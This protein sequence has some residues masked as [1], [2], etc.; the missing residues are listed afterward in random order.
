MAPRS[1]VIVI[2]STFFKR[3]FGVMVARSV[4]LKQNIYRKEIVSETI[5]E[6]LQAR[7]AIE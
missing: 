7:T 5:N 1:T 3:V 4:H 2:D 6:Y